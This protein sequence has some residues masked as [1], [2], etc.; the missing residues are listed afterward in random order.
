MRIKDTSW[1]SEAI[2][3]PDP[4]FFPVISHPGEHKKLSI[5]HRIFA[6][7]IKPVRD[8]YCS[9]C[10]VQEQCF[11]YGI[12]TGSEGIYGGC[13]LLGKGVV[14]N[15]SGRQITLRQNTEV[16]V[17]LKAFNRLLGRSSSRAS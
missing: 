4:R 12:R 15:E 10:P 2:C 13:L 8:Q 16:G 6:T 14:F 5:K 3:K 17:I 1:M 7:K 9:R 11:I